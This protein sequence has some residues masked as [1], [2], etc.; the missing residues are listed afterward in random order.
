MK[1]VVTD[2][3]IFIDVIDLQLTSRFFGL[4]FE[5]HTTTD[6]I[7]ELYPGQQEILKAFEFAG[8]LT[9]HTLTTQDWI[10]IQNQNFPRSLSPEDASVI[11][12]A[13]RL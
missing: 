7:N 2:A 12:T 3:C 4:E 13:Q 11:F 1:L 8:K 9:I 5:V 6:V 10:A